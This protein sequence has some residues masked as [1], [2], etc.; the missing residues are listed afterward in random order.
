[1]FADEYDDFTGV[2]FANGYLPGDVPPPYEIYVSEDVCFAYTRQACD[3]YLERHPEDGE[4]VKTLL[5]RIPE[6]SLPPSAHADP[7]SRD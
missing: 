2:Y 5:A 7:A 6:Q 1:M 4:K 3:K